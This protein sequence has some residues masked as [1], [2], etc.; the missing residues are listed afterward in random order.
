MVE[1][2]NFSSETAHASKLSVSQV[3]TISDL[4]CHFVDFEMPAYYG[5]SEVTMEMS[6]CVVENTSFNFVTNRSV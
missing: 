5:T 2:L 3:K 1:K 6:F 4:Q